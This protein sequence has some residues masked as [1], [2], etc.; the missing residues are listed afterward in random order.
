MTSEKSCGAVVFTRVD[1]EVRYL[2]KCSRNVETYGI[3]LV[4]LHFGLYFLFGKPALVR[5]CKFQLVA[6]ELSFF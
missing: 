2:V 5:E 1:G 4:V 3:H 6:I